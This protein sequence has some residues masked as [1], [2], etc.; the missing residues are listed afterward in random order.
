MKG[1]FELTR[2]EPDQSICEPGLIPFRFWMFGKDPKGY[3]FIADDLVGNC[4]SETANV[5]E[6]AAL[7]A[8]KKEGIYLEGIELAMHVVWL[9]RT[10]A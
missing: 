3:K 10:R 5:V 8:L 2:P 9:S 4:P 7:E 6:Q 1:S